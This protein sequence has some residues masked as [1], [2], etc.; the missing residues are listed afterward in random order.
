MRAK[1]ITLMI[2]VSVLTMSS[3]SSL[4]SAENLCDGSTADMHECI[5][6]KYLIA[7][8]ELNSV[9]QALRARLKKEASDKDFGSD[10]VETD[11]RLVAA[12]RAW[13]T[14]RDADCQLAATEMLGGS[15]EGLI[16]HGCL[17]ERTLER[18]KALK[19]Y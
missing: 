11:R 1:F 18:V 4:A 12:Q 19:A 6:A 5:G 16:V 17:L 10:A 14:F 9:Y 13:I 8:K 2:A 3:F 15:G 7:D